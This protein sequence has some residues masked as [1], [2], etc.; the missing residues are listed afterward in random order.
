MNKSM[1]HTAA[2]ETPS[3]TDEEKAFQKIIRYLTYCD[4]TTY[5]LHC[6][7]ANAGFSEEVIQSSLDRVC[8]AGFVNDEH[9]AQRLIEQYF[10][11]GK[12]KNAAIASLKKKGIP[13]NVINQ[14]LLE[15]S[16][17]EEDESARALTYLYRHPPRGKNLHDSAFRKLISKGYS[18]SAASSA[19]SSYCS[20]QTT[21]N[22]SEF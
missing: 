5:E 6:K 17:E 22:N 7:L 11:A 14:L 15:S 18:V 21:D 12:G 3:L 2:K 19:A 16:Y 4:R 8:H 9:L 10:Q 1:T 20:K 13:E